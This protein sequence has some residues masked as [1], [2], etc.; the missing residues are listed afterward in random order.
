M[1]ISS[2]IK[3][4]NLT[5]KRLLWILSAIKTCLLFVG[6]L[7]IGLIASH[8]SRDDNNNDKLY[9]LLLN[10]FSEYFIGGEFAVDNFNELSEVIAGAVRGFIKNND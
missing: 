3:I 10:K 8:I 1:I 5:L 9:F 7:S 2:N 4:K 6:I